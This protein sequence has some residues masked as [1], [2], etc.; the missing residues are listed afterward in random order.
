MTKKEL[1]NITSS[2]NDIKIIIDQHNELLKQ[3]SRVRRRLK[4]LLNDYSFLSDLVSINA[5][6]TIL[7]N[8]LRIFFNKL[9]Y[10]KV[11]CVGKKFKEEDVRLWLNDKLIIFEVTGSKN[12]IPTD[13]KTFQIIKHR[14]VRQLKYPNLKVF[15]CFV[16]NHDNK[17]PFGQRKHDPFDKRLE[18]LALANNVCICTTTD[19]VNAFSNYK[20]GLITQDELIENLCSP[21]ILK[22]F[23]HSQ[24]PVL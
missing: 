3:T 10:D 7:D 21:G 1:K 15:A 9:G 19:L 14:P 20:K 5:T 24:S 23:G 17:K 4:T 8:A 2:F 11:E 18:K 12:D 6:D 22:I 16:I 13:D